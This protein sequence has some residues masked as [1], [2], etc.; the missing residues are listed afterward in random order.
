[1]P[2][3]FFKTSSNLIPLRFRDALL[4]RLALGAAFFGTKTLSAEARLA[5]PGFHQSI[6][7]LG[8]SV[9]S[10]HLPIR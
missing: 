10:D 8:E 3:I 9:K 5:L 6:N 1:M 7:G 4:G 2:S